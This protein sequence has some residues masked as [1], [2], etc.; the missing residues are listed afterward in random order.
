MSSRWLHTIVL[1]LMLVCHDSASGQGDKPSE[2]A[3]TKTPT[4]DLNE[5]LEINRDSLLRGST[6][7]I[8]VKAAILI[9]QDPSPAA[10]KILL[11][12]LNTAGNTEAVA[13][14]CKALGQARTLEKPITVL[15]DLFPPILNLLKRPEGPLGALAAEACLFFDYET[16]GPN[17]E[18]LVADVN[19]P[20]AVRLNLVSVLRQFPDKRVAIRFLRLVDDPDKQVARQV[21][22]GLNALGV[23]VGKDAADRRAIIA[24]LEST[25]KD[26]F[27]RDAIIAKLDRTSRDDSLRNYVL[28]QEKRI[29]QER[30]E[31]ELW[32]QLYLESLDRLYGA[33]TEDTQRGEFL[34]QHLKAAQTAR[35][36]WALAKAY[37]WRMAAGSN[38]PEVMSP[39]L[40]GLLS[41]QDRTVRLSTARLMSKMGDASSAKVLLDRLEVEPDAQV[42]SA[43]FVA[44]GM[45]CD[46]ALMEGAGGHVDPEVKRKTLEWAGRFL[47]QSDPNQIREGANVISKLVAKNGLTDAEVVSYL[48]LLKK[49]L[50][51]EDLAASVPARADLLGAMASLCLRRSASRAQAIQLFE[52]LFQKARSDTNDRIR[53]QAIEGLF[54][55]DKGSALSQLRKDYP[56]DSSA[57]IR[58]HLME[59]A[60]EV[61]EAADLNWL[62]GRLAQSQDRPMAWEGIN[63]IVGRLDVVTLLSWLKGALAGQSPFT[64]DQAIS[65][66]QA[67][68]RKAMG[69]KWAEQRAWTL[70]ELAQRQRAKGDPATAI[71]TILRLLELQPPKAHSALK[72]EL[73]LLYLEVG[74]LE[75][76]AKLVR[77]RLEKTD[78]KEG[79]PVLV[80][81]ENYRG[82]GSLDDRNKTLVQ[83]VGKIASPTPRPNWE[84]YKTQWLAQPKETTES[85]SPTPEKTTN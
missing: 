59:A 12:T 45:A 44:L 25:S 21:V 20:T 56:N 83:L 13:A 76:A 53:E 84:Q 14:V 42:R 38:L 40:L 2:E 16:V 17:L 23:D 85:P 65:L 18:I 36:R 81:I 3:V 35:R 61:G 32:R 71:K 50:Q 46:L 37:E 62:T 58:Y 79:D 47:S 29:Q 66:L 78:V 68:E 82:D 70:R 24:R 52:P 34:I 72:G 22:K 64:L 5:Q 55:A 54:N 9:L 11:D 80:A 67:L 26:D 1:L 10:H 57:A 74:Q 28:G 63:S 75:E 6:E 39:V 4:A 8:R 48:D 31:M 69:E 33:L 73:V 49:R 60:A 77:E 7:Q 19:Q 27:L 41:D 30:Q 51:A 43:L 15:K